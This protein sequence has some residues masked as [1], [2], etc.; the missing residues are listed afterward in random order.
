MSRILESGGGRWTRSVWVLPCVAGSIAI[1][2]FLIVALCR[3]NYPFAL[4]WMEGGAIDHVSRILSGESIYV[5]PSLDFVPF[6]YTPL[7]FYVSALL[8]LIVGEGFLP[9]RLVSLLSTTGVLLALYLV[10]AREGGD[11]TAGF[12]AAALF[13]ATFHASGA[14]MDLARVD[15]LFVL[16]FAL[17]ILVLRRPASRASMV[18]AGVLLSLCFLTKQTAA[19]LSVPLVLHA[20][21][22]HGRRATWFVGSLAGLSSGASLLLVHLTEG[23]YSYYLLIAGQDRWIWSKAWRFWVHDLFLPFPIALVAAGTALLLLARRGERE[24]LGFWASLFAFALAAALLSRARSGGYLNVLMPMHFVLAALFGLGAG[25]LRSWGGKERFRVARLV[26]VT[27]VG[28]CLAQFALLAYNPQRQ[29]PTQEDRAAGWEV[30]SALEKTPGEVLLPLHAYLAGMAGKR[31]YLQ[32]NGGID[33]LRTTDNPVKEELVVAIRE[34][35]RSRKFALIVL[36]SHGLLQWNNFTSIFQADIEANYS[37][38][39]RLLEEGDVFW[40]VT[41]AGT[42]PEE[43]WVPR[44][45]VGH[46]Q[47]L[48]GARSVQP[49]AE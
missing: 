3:M 11:R 36:D 5:S 26:Q 44:P 1:L 43:R 2:A 32:G 27:A 39:G 42:R 18:L 4:E 7:Y 12:L 38:S 41:G 34:A 6:I 14:W 9:L 13:A 15:S 31:I 8:T 49:M 23:W 47:N 19:I 46:A 30:V 22:Y 25:L 20:I 29:I 21:V 48:P 24:K 33:C 10:V 35:I 16:L 45:R 40:P 28:A 37:R 17:A